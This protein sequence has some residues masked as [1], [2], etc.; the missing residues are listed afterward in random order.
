MT[1]KPDD[2]EAVRSVADTLQ[3]YAKGRIERNHGTHQDRL[4]KRNCGATGLGL[5]RWPKNA[6]GGVLGGEQVRTS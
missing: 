1:S 6:R 5:R 4:V 3:P 2:L